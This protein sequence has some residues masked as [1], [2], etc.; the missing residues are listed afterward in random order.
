[1]TTTVTRLIKAPVELVFDVIS[2]I[3]NFSRAVPAIISTEFIGDL[4]HG[5]GTRFRETRSMQG[6]EMTVELEVTEFVKNKH[7]RIISDTNG[8]LWDSVFTVR[9]DGEFTELNLIMEA[10]TDR[11]FSKIINKV[12]SGVITKAVEKDLD[13]IKSYCENV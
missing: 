6:R 1:M 13:S 9:P 10:K 5:V 4:K 8:T 11:F 2:D 12:M 3:G 7:I